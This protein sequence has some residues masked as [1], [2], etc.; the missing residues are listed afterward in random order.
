MAA[1]KMGKTM[2]SPIDFLVTETRLN[3]ANS[4][5]SFNKR[6]YSCAWLKPQP[7]LLFAL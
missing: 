5:T 4:A 7:P 1:Q 2:F 3:S 6:H